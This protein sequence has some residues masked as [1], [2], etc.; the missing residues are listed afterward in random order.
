PPETQV[1]LTLK[2]VCGFSVAEIGRAF[3]TQETTIAQRLVRAKHT[4]QEK[5]IPIAVPP[6]AEMPIRLDSVLHVIYLL[7]NEG[8][9]AHQGDDL[10]R[11]DLCEEA[12][13]LGR[14]LTRKRETALPKV[15]ALLALMF[16]QASR[17]PARVNESG[18]M[19]LIAD[20][21]RSQWDQR[22]IFAGLRH[23]DAA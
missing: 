17:L 2:A 9:T 5:A 12:I 4:I 19:L 10:V 14:W 11:L 22:F 1:A 23:L 15:H 6:V 20:Q 16:L 3:L 18:E 7:F 21:D 13:R 8:Y